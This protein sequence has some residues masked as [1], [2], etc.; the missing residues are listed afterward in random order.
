MA[1]FPPHKSLWRGSMGRRKG[2]TVE[3]TDEIR[4]EPR[5]E[6]L[7]L[8][9]VCE[10]QVEYERIRPLLLFDEPVPERARQTGTSERT[11]YRKTA[12]FRDRKMESVFA[13]SPKARRRVL[14]PAIRRAIVD[15]KAEHPPLNLEEI[16][17]I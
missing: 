3:P 1:Y 14:P 5:W 10:E 11:L 16:A 9:C 7:E 6:Q 4:Y 15:L 8:L 17:N 13:S 2:R 12:A